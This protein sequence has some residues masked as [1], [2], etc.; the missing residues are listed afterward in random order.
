MATEVVP[1]YGNHT[2]GM[3]WLGDMDCYNSITRHSGQ[4]INYLKFMHLYK[5]KSGN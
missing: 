1:C 2:L 5:I 3:I 4:I